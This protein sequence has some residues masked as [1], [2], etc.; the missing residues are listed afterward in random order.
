MKNFQALK[1]LFLLLLMV[2]FTTQ[3]TKATT[4]DDA[5]VYLNGGGDGLLRDLY[6]NLSSASLSQSDCIKGKCFFTFAIS[7]DGT[8]DVET[9]RLVRKTSLPDEYVNAAKES[10][11]H[12]GKFQ[13]GRRFNSK[14]EKWEPQ[15]VQYTIVVIFPIPSKYL[16][17]E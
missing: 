5:P 8:I 1:I 17:S 10:I 2:S 4:V 14:E 11:K 3:T 9:I 7:K 16:T 6:C 13:P 15:R 12:L